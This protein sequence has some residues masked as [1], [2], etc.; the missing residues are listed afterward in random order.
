MQNLFDV[1]RNILLL[2]G[3]LFFSIGFLSI[4]LSMIGFKFDF[5]S[6]LNKIG[7]GFAFI[8]YIFL[9]LAGIAMMYVAKDRP[10]IEQKE[11]NN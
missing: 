5:L 4:I 11:L 8:V 3:F 10:V 2:V 1:K 7:Y 9:V 6:F